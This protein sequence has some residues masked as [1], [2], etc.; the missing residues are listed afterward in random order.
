MFVNVIMCLYF[1]ALIW[2]ENHS[3]TE[4]F[5]KHRLSVDPDSLLQTFVSNMRRT[6][7][8][9]QYEWSIVKN[10]IVVAGHFGRF[11]AVKKVVVPRAGTVLEWYYRFKLSYG[12][13]LHTASLNVNMVEAERAKKVSHFSMGTNI[14]KH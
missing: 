14:S 6:D 2:H 1:Q 8:P 3:S 10:Y 11:L 9:F 4:L 13:A 5:P 12:T 7:G